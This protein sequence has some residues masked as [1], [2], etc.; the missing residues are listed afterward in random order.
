MSTQASD[1][2]YTM[3]DGSTDWA[4]GRRRKKKGGG[5]AG[6]TEYQDQNVCPRVRVGVP[7]IP[8]INVYSCKVGLF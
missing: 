2:R 4:G 8:T 3:S 7:R 6:S 1:L 5:V